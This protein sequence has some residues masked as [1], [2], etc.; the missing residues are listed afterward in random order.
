MMLKIL[1]GVVVTA[2]AL[3]FLVVPRSGTPEAARYDNMAHSRDVIGQCWTDQG[4]KSLA[5]SAARFSASVCEKME[6][7][8][9]VTHRQNP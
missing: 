3:W 1:G 9:R 6:A 5:P 8:F 2:F 7:D 4:R